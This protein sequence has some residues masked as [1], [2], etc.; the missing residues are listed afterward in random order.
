ML[1]LAL[2]DAN[3]KFL[4]V[5]VGAAGRAGDAGVFNNSTL[6][7]ALLNGSLDIPLPR[8]IMESC[9]HYHI[10]GDDAFPMSLALMKP[11]PHRHLEK[12][13]R[14]Y[15]YRLSRARRVVE[16]AFGIL[17][18]RFRVFHTLIN[19]SPER[20]TDLLLAACCLH[21]YLVDKNKSAYTSACDVEDIQNHLINSGA[22][23]RDPQLLAMSP[24]LD[25]NPVR[26]A[27]EQRQ[28]LT[29]YFSSDSGSVPWQEQMI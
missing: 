28:D 13:K 16:N 2:V 19:L 9:I 17:A 20:V 24:C 6:K 23:R 21:N 12:E 5:D 7:E 1:L 11:Y 29:T 8:K 14:I 18:N 4:Y 25:R 15:N 27:K 10:I 3:Y 22:W 26:S